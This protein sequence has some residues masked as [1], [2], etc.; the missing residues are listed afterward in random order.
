MVTSLLLA[1][2]TFAS[3]GPA[4]AMPLQEEPMVRV[5]TN[6]GDVVKTGD[7]VRVYVETV[8]DGYLFV[9]HA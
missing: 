1:T 9:L 6:K 4:P 2:M 5:W 8:E 3:A 7:R